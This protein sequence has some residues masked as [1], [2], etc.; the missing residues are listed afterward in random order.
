MTASAV[1]HLRALYALSSVRLLPA[2]QH[3]VKQWLCL[4]PSVLCHAATVYRLLKL[5]MIQQQYMVVCLSLP[6]TSRWAAVS[7]CCFT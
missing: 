3:A 1:V 7:R 6:A 5:V 4:L 2:Q